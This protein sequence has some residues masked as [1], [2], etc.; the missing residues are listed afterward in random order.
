MLL[1]LSL[2]FAGSLAL[3]LICNSQAKTYNAWHF[4][5]EPLE[6]RTLSETGKFALLPFVHLL[7]PLLTCISVLC[8]RFASGFGRAVGAVQDA[9]REGHPVRP[10]A[11]TV[12]SFG[13]C[14]GFW[15]EHFVFC[16]ETRSV[17]SDY[18]KSALALEQFGLWSRAQELY[19]GAMS[20]LQTHPEDALVRAASRS[21]TMMWEEEWVRCAKN[22][23]QWDVSH[24]VCFLCSPA[25]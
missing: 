6:T 14:C 15:T 17:N 10:L 11:T 3:I 24:S 16:F 25:P 12:C 21:E 19:Y 1:F 23:N 4:A 2:Y 9:E 5:I 13:Q 20:K 22:L 18:S 8:S 7:G